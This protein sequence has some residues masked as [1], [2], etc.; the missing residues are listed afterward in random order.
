LKK[1]IY[2]HHFETAHSF[3]SMNGLETFATPQDIAQAL[4][5]VESSFVDANDDITLTEHFETFASFS[6]DT[7]QQ[8]RFHF[9]AHVVHTEV[10]PHQL[11]PDDPTQFE[12]EE[13]RCLSIYW[14]A[15]QRARA[16]ALALLFVAKRRLDIRRWMALDIWRLMARM[17]A[18]EEIKFL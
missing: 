1:A 15:R 17:V 9:G 13:Y 3:L 14:R 2:Q 12:P 18:G 4:I 11:D 10:A 8:I 7:V 6:P 5:V 16:A